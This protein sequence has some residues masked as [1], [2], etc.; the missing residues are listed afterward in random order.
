MLGGGKMW[1][2]V[3]RPGEHSGIWAGKVWVE[4]PGEDSAEEAAGQSWAKACGHLKGTRRGREGEQ[5][6]GQW[7]RG[8]QLIH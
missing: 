6:G 3:E 1:A 5:A 7:G 2:G 8:F 4:R